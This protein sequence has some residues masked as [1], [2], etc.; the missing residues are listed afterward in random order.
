MEHAKNGGHARVGAKAFGDLALRYDSWYDSP[1]G[2]RIFALECACLAPL[3]APTAHPRLEVGVG[4]GRFAQ[5]LE[6]DVGVDIAAPPLALAAARAIHV[7]RADARRLPF[8][9]DSFGA[10]VAIMTMCFV[11]DPVALVAEAR[12]VL[13][14]DATL[15]LGTVRADSAWGEAYQTMGRAGHAFYRHAHF[16]SLA[17]TLELVTSQ[18]FELT[19]SRSTLVAAPGADLDGERV[20]EGVHPRASFVALSA[21]RR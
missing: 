15:V 18:G 21:T 12:R 13:V 6:I 17:D 1:L 20:H 4:S 8:A 3:L 16:S 11:D 19:G 7:V 9:S 5:A 10:V 14:R 2:S